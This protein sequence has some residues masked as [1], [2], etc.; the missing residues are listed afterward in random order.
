MRKFLLFVLF[1]I[2][3][4]GNVFAADIE[5]VSTRLTDQ[6]LYGMTTNEEDPHT[7]Y[8]SSEEIE[9]FTQSINRHFVGIGVQY[10]KSRRPRNRPRDLQA[11]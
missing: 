4:T 1:V 7:S 6:A 11:K 9:S 10:T 8:M 5:D 3:M 2:S